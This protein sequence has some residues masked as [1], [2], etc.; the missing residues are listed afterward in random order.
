MKVS[1]ALADAVAR[2]ADG[3]VF[4]LMGD[5]N[6]AVWDAILKAGRTRIVWSRHDGAAILMADGYAQASGRIGIATVTCGPGLASGANALLSAARAG[7]PMVVLTGEYPDDGR[8]SVQHLDTRRFATACE[9]EFRA[10]SKLDTL[11]E[12]VAEAFFLA[13]MRSRP[14]L[15]CVPYAHWDAELEWPW[16]YRP[17]SELLPRQDWAAPADAIVELAERLFAAQRPV[18]LAGRGAIRADARAALEG[19]GDHVG[20]LFATSLVAKGFF[21]GHPYDL[22]ISGSFSSAPAET[23]MAEA[24]LV[25]AFG[26]SLNHYT[27]EGGLLFPRAA[28]ARVDI[29]PPAA[30]GAVPGLYL[31]ADAR[32]AAEALLRA[33]QKLG[34]SREGFRSAA[35]R[36]TL[37][38]PTPAPPG[39]AD[40]L[41]P[42]ALMRALSVALPPR[43]QVVT[44]AGHFWSWPIAHLALPVG[45]R[46][47][48]TGSF[49]SIGLG[50]GNA[51]GAALAD[52]GRL[53]V[54]V[55]GDGSLLQAIQELHAAA[56]QKVRLAILV[57]N[58]AA[59]G[60]E[61]LKMQWKGRD[62]RDAQW[63]SPDFVALAKSFGGDGMRLERE[64][65]VTTAI[66]RASVCEGPYVIDARI[67]P[68]LVS[69][70]YSR[71]FLAQPNSMPLLRP[72][73]HS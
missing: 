8:S 49:G 61:V 24:D 4:G 47:Q 67:S 70:A 13:R 55:E 57:M 12:D 11:A 19:L 27:T 52:P 44:G 10:L 25:L 58:D 22:G 66:E 16:E 48:H 1:Q 14:V 59:Y 54:L 26:A 32:R 23:L 45:G 15:L 62:A 53:T 56:E 28:V 7:T 51:I 2:E 34:A 43:T 18:L 20:A 21:D 6:M 29:R 35:T 42:R 3:L 31:Q 73:H 60:A 68:T 50:L 41:D 17:S 40:G 63:S 69:D 38:S 5:A 72:A 46:F 33:V 37:S 64:Q 30:I 9:C 71:L 65:D 39:P 36:D